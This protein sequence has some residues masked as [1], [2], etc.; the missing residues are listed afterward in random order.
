MVNI[1]EQLTNILCFELTDYA[2]T[3]GHLCIIGPCRG[4]GKDAK[5][6]LQMFDTVESENTTM[7]SRDMH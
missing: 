4:L 3:L 6:A 7:I 2:P 5:L 1:F